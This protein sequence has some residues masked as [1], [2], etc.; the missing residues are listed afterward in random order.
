MNTSFTP[1]DFSFILF[2]VDRRKIARTI[3]AFLID[4]NNEDVIFKIHDNIPYPWSCQLPGKYKITDSGKKYHLLEIVSK[5]EEYK[6]DDDFFIPK[7]LIYIKQSKL[8]SI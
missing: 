5:I 3:N 4:G 2:K 7:L 1:D 8:E 6:K